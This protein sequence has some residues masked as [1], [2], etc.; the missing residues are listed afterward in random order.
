MRKCMKFIVNRWEDVI[1][2]KFATV[3]I[4]G[5]LALSTLTGCNVSV[6]G[7]TVLE[8]SDEDVEKLK[9]TGKQVANKVGDIV[10]D[11]AVQN[12]VKDAAGSIK[13]AATK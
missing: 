6:N 11:E 10:T 7:K 1:M 3:A 2:K 8:A 12:A 13:D 4:I 5:L 9:E